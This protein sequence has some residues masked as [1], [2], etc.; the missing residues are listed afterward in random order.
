MIAALL[1]QWKKNTMNQAMER[2][3]RKPFVTYILT[4][5]I[6]ELNSCNF[7]S[8]LPVF[9]MI[10]MSRLPQAL[11]RQAAAELLSLSATPLFNLQARRIVFL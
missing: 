3:V 6:V 10:W 2:D 1:L 4:A 5:N 11:P 7:L 9:G 8:G